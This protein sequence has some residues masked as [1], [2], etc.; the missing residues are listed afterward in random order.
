MKSKTFFSLNASR[1]IKEK[2]AAEFKCIELERVLFNYFL[3]NLFQFYI[4]LLLTSIGATALE[5]IEKKFACYEHEIINSKAKLTSIKLQ[6][7]KL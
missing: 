3:I 1:G 5:C 6:S 2:K 4:D 7:F